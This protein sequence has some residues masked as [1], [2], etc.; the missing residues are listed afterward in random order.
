MVIGGGDIVGIALGVVVHFD[1][2]EQLVGITGLDGALG[3]DVTGRTGRQSRCAVATGDVG[4]PRVKQIACL[5]L[6]LSEP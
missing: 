2:I 3:G 6:R 5:T 1:F 4:I